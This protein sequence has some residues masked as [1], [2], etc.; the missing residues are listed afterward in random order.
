MESS[1]TERESRSPVGVENSKEEQNDIWTRTKDTH[2]Y[3]LQSSHTSPSL[4][5]DCY[6]RIS[7]TFSQQLSSSQNTTQYKSI[8]SIQSFQTTMMKS[9]LLFLFLTFTLLLPASTFVLAADKPSSKSPSAL[10]PPSTIPATHK[11]SSARASSTKMFSFPSSKKENISAFAGKIAPVLSKLYI[12]PVKAKNIAIAIR[13]VT[14][15]ADLVFILFVGWFLLPLAQL[16][17]EKIYM[18]NEV[19]GQDELTKDVVTT[20]PVKVKKPFKDTKLYFYT[21]LVAEAGQIAGLVYLID[22]LAIALEV[23]GFNVQNHSKLCAKTIYTAWLFTRINGLRKYLVGKAFRYNGPDERRRRKIHTRAQVVNQLLDIILWGA[24]VSSLLDILKVK[25]GV[26]LN[27]FFAVG[28]VGT[29]LLSFASKDI[30]MQFVSGFALQASDKVYEG[31]EVQFG[32]GVKGSVI[33]M[34]IL[35]TLVK[36]NGEMITAVPNKDLA[37]QRLT[38]LSRLKY[39]QVTQTLRFDYKDADKIPSIIDEIRK[40]I[41]TTCPKVVTDGSR[42]F[43]V[44]WSTYAES[45]LEVMV[46]IRMST[47]PIGDDYIEGKQG[48]LMAIHRALKRLNVELVAPMPVPLKKD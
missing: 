23:L 33:R 26:F 44:F 16:P 14:E 22:C 12:T 6:E 47:P 36:H 40:E 20:A 35:E 19:L 32:N 18:R 25:A 34:G 43:R 24:F 10:D 46:D 21:H 11:T 1:N 41:R 4:I 7:F 30:A 8:Y 17:Y 37:N 5:S 45:C 29:L 48:V 42:P 38:N 2:V 13:T 9:R 15:P 3:A 27:S 31:E 39:S 28:G